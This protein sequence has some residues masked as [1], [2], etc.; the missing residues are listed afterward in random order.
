[1]IFFIHFLQYWV[2]YSE[3]HKSVNCQIL[4]KIHDIFKIPLTTSHLK[5]GTAKNQMKGIITS[6]HKTVCAERSVTHTRS[7]KG[8]FC[9]ISLE[10][11]G[12]I[13]S[14]SRPKGLPRHKQAVCPS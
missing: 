1:M 13:H 14:H 11:L 10:D 4:H 3:V 12:H 9:F 8:L 7:F 5:A 2:C 6:S